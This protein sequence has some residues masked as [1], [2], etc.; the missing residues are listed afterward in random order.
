MESCHCGGFLMLKRRSCHQHHVLQFLF[1]LG[2]YLE[3][4]V[5]LDRH[6]D[7]SCG[8]EPEAAALLLVLVSPV[9]LV[10]TTSQRPSPHQLLIP[11]MVFQV[12]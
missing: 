1:L 5:D 9:L 3:V 8:A 7:R 12:L 11:H 2:A 6:D 10:Y 4:E